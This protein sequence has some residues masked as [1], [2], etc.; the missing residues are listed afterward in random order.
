MN[1]SDYIKDF[2]TASQ[3]PDIALAYDQAQLRMQKAKILA[4][5][6]CMPQNAA[7]QWAVAKF[8]EIL[9]Y[10][11][12]SIS[13]GEDEAKKAIM[14]ERQVVIEEKLADMENYVE[15]LPAVFSFYA[16]KTPNLFLITQSFLNTLEK[17]DYHAFVFFMNTG[18]QIEALY[19]MQ[20]YGWKVDRIEQVCKYYGNDSD[21]GA[22]EETAFIVR[23]NFESN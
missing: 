19:A 11:T 2:K 18:A 4:E 6:F 1:Y 16:Y 14:N 9:D 10:V 17:N 20:L 12:V 22:F 13:Y 7:L 5:E 8:N 23:K 15:N 3:T 21:A